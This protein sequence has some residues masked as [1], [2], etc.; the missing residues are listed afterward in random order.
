MAEQL[1]P[2]RAI[3]PAAAVVP[4]AD[5]PPVDP[6]ALFKVMYGLFV[7]TAC[8]NGR[9]NGCIINTVN[10][11]TN[12]PN[13]LA[14]AVNSFNDTHGMIERTDVQCACSPRAPVSRFS[15]GLATI[16]AIRTSSQILR[17]RA[18]KTGWYS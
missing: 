10:Q 18:A 9:D 6:M 2:T 3:A 13:R 1:W 12:M 7:L 8:E 5:L 14:I 17:W 4:A 15:S 11:I 16:A